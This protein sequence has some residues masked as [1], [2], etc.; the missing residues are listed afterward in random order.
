VS[1]ARVLDGCDAVVALIQTA[2]T[3]ST[4]PPGANDGVRRDYAPPINLSQDTAAPLTGRQVIVFPG[5]YQWPQIDRETQWRRYSIR[6]LVV[7]KY[8]PTLPAPPPT[9]W[10]DTRVAFVEQ[11]VV[12]TLA[13]PTNPLTGNMVVDPDDPGGIDLLYSPDDLIELQT[14]WSVATFHYREETTLQG[15]HP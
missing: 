7:E 15:V 8:D 13:D 5:P 11:I 12:N 10:I 3:N 2:W 4:S 1:N 9:A 6:V 14:F